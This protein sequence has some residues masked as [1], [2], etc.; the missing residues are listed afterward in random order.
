MFALYL[1]PYTLYLVFSGQKILPQ[2]FNIGF[3][4]MHYYGLFIALAAA[5]GIYFSLRRAERFGLTKKQAEDIL[6]WAIIGGFLGAR[7][8]HIL[9]SGAYYIENPGD[10][11]KVWQGGLSIYG[12][13]FGGF[14]ALWLCRNFFIFHF[15]FLTCLNWLTPSLILGQV[16]GR[17]GNLFNYELYGYPTNLPWKM[18]VPEA[19]RSLEF[20]SNSFYHPLFLYEQIGL[21]L[22][23]FLL[24]IFKKNLSLVVKKFKF[25]D[26]NQGL[27]VYYIL[28]YNILRFALE[29]LRVDS[30]IY[31]SL[32]INAIVSLALVIISA[33]YLFYVRKKQFN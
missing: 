22:I 3:F 20:S 32:R 27:F 14:F 25:L 5:A 17:F 24:T 21:L 12:A 15:S 29:F 13:V 31:W 18:F 8:Y 7:I 6:F 11:L 4:S 30:V 16:V 33:S 1:I 9:T 26:L 28:L 19:F 23:L 2:A 10:I